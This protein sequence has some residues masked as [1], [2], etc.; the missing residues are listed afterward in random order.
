VEKVGG[1]EVEKWNG[2]TSQFFGFRI[3]PQGDKLMVVHAQKKRKHIVADCTESPFFPPRV[4][5]PRRPRQKNMQTP[6][7]KADTHTKP[8]STG[9][10]MQE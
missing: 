1:A 3:M 10:I 5:S 2:M 9:Q 6:L 8:L 7:S 4:I